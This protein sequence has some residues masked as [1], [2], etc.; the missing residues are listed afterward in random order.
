M[1]PGDKCEAV[2]TGYDDDGVKRVGNCR[3][4]AGWGTDH[5]GFGPCRKHGGSMASHAVHA[6]TEQFTLDVRERIGRL[7]VTPVDDPLTELARL[8]GEVVA[9]KDA[10]AERVS[11]LTD[12][13]YDGEKSGEQIRGEVIVFERA[14][15]RC[16]AV[17][18]SMAKLNIDERMARVTEKQ[19]EFVANALATAMNHMGLDVHQQQEARALVAR[20]LRLVAGE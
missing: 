10:I 12:I 5:V 7:I 8:A 4:P 18:T 1:A 19:A 20:E 17:L 13:R 14:L 3:K 16:N 9:W 2:L 11:F 6:A 15:D